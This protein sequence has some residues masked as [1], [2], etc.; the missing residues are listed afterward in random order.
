MIK[1]CKLYF[2]FF[3]VCYWNGARY[4]RVFLIWI[5]EFFFVLTD[6]K[7]K[8]LGTISG[9]ASFF[10]CISIRFSSFFFKDWISAVELTTGA[11]RFFVMVLRMFTISIIFYKGNFR[12]IAFIWEIWPMRIYIWE[13]I[14]IWFLNIRPIWLECLTEKMLTFSFNFEILQLWGKFQTAMMSC[15]RFIL[16]YLFQWLLEGLN[17]E[18]LAYE[19]VT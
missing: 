1:N 11:F 4:E 6:L 9:K 7:W 8:L 18:S 12:F 10:F 17:C 15:L 19:V 3:K 5:W 14:Y 13:L 16:D 2:V